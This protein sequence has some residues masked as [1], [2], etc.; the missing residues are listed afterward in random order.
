MHAMMRIVPPQPRRSAHLMPNTRFRRCAQRIAGRR[1]AVA[2]LALP[3]PGDQCP[4]RTVGCEHAVVAGEVHP[5]PGHQRSQPRQKIQRLEHNVCGAVAVG[6]FEPFVVNVR[7]GDAAAQAFEFLALMGASRKSN[8]L[9]N[10]RFGHT[11]E[12][13]GLHSLTAAFENG[14]DR[15]TLSFI[16]G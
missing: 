10:G 16:P 8:Y 15:R 9:A 14:A 3:G 6:T 1:S 5:Q 13:Q 2:A 7:A 12:V 11:T 4:V